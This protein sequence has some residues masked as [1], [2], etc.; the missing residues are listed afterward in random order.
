M[1]AGQETIE[2]LY[3]DQ[4]KVDAQWAVK[5]ASGFTWWAD[6]NAQ[7]VAVKGPWTN[8]WGAVDSLV[9]V[10]TEFLRKAPP[11]EKT[12]SALHALLMPLASMA[13]PVYDEEKRTVKL[14]SLVPVHDEICAWMS[15]LISVAC[16]LQIGEARIMQHEIAKF[17]NAEAAESGHPQNGMRPDPDELAEGIATLVVPLGREPCKWTQEEFEAAVEQ[18]MQDPP[19]LGASGGGSSLTVEVPYGDFSSLCQM[20]GDAPH[21]RY[22]NGLLLVQSFPIRKASEQEGIRLA[23]SLNAISLRT[24][25]YGYGFGS[26][27]YRDGTVHFTSFFPNLVHKPGLLRNI[28]FS[29]V[30]RAWEVNAKLSQPGPL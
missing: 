29:C 26:Y 11:G 28:Y 7:H 20:S 13:G 8:P 18:Y 15:R 27:C 5:D 9:T 1:N 14:C 6:R 24:R 17:L 12:S 10:E 4:L 19:S 2:W 25:P 23:F 16:I 3:R 22:G 21:P 30:A